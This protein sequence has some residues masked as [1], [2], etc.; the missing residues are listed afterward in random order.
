MTIRKML[1]FFKQ[2]RPLKNQRR[3]GASL[4]NEIDN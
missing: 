1:K 3:Q 4:A 2:G